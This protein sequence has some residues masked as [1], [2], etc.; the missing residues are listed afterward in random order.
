ML[1]ARRMKENGLHFASVH[2]SFW[3]HA[4]DIEKMNIFLREEF[5]KLYSQDLLQELKNCFEKIHP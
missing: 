1:T 3:T 5:V 2:D 4:T